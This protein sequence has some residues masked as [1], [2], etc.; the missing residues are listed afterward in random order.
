MDGYPEGESGIVASIKRLQ[1]Y[2]VKTGSTLDA[3]HTAALFICLDKLRVAQQLYEIRYKEGLTVND[4]LF[5]WEKREI[6][7]IISWGYSVENVEQGIHGDEKFLYKVFHDSWDIWISNS[8]QI[9]DVDPKHA[10]K[11]ARWIWKGNLEKAYEKY[12]IEYE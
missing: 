4:I 7:P 6:Y 2:I 10:F 3:G 1:E 5:P 11:N 12:V 9:W 8:W